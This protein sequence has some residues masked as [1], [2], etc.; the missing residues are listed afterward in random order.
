MTVFVTADQHFR[1]ANIIKY[2]D[3]PFATV[4]EM[5]AEMIR[6]WNEVVSIFD[7][8]YVLG[9]FA[10]APIPL[11]S[12]IL[13]QL[14]GTKFLIKGNH[15]RHRNGQLEVAGFS[16]VHGGA[17][18]WE[19]GDLN[20]YLTH[21]PLPVG[22]GKFNIHGHIHNLMTI[23]GGRNYCVSVE[24]TNYYPVEIAPIIDTFYLRQG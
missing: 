11:I 18:I 5:D 23:E 1:H 20:V 10:L 21:A 2:C 22:P 19:E 3:R 7:T 24:Q 16:L 15:D 17:W 14:H 9:D 6:R 8:V 12:D 13:L 4:D